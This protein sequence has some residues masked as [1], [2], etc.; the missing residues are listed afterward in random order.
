[1]TRTAVDAHHS[2]DPPHSDENQPPPDRPQVSAIQEFLANHVSGVGLI[3]SGV[4]LI[5]T[6][7]QAER[8]AT[9]LANQCPDPM[10]AAAGI[11]ELVSNAIEHGNL[12]IS[13]DAK[14]ELLKTGGF[15]AEIERRHTLEPFASRQVRIEFD[16]SDADVVVTI[17]D[18][19]DGFDYRYYLDCDLSYDR[20]NGRGLYVASRYAFDELTFI[21]KGN[22]VRA[23]MRG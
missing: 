12:G 3:R 19:G 7:L 17:A 16:R 2:S 11:W 14:T 13:Y 23:V 9:M 10:R 22:C 20:P 15:E 5:R 18:E 6:H 21:G 1:M 8:L 4:F